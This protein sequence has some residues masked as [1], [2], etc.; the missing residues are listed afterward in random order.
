MS[1]PSNEP[2]TMDIMIQITRMEGKLD[3]YISTL[4]KDVEDHE[5]RLR[6]VEKRIWSIPT[7]AGLINLLMLAV[8]ALTVFIN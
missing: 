5:A 1:T 4:P 3:A 7:A 6:V 8:T 2:S